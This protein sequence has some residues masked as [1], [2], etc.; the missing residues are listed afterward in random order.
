MRSETMGRKTGRPSQFRDTMILLGG[1]AA[2]AGLI[3]GKSSLRK[4]MSGG[5][6]ALLT[7]ALIPDLIRY[8][9]SR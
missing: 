9:K 2:I 5:G 3:S 7:S 1:A 8:A 4:Y 6:L